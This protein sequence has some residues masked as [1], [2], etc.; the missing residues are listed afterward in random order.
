MYAQIAV[1]LWVRRMGQEILLPCHESGS[2][3]INVSEKSWNYSIVSRFVIKGSAP[4]FWEEAPTQETLKFF[5]LRPY[6][7]FILDNHTFV[8]FFLS[9][10]HT[11]NEDYLV[12]LR[13]HQLN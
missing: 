10:K 9:M 6:S 5:F 11:Y 12:N 13:K 1:T 4:S 3:N 8:N 7:L 2:Y